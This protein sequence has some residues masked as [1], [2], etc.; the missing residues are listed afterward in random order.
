MQDPHEVEIGQSADCSRFR[1]AIEA[2]QSA[3]LEALIVAADASRP[4]AARGAL[5]ASPAGH[6][7][8]NAAFDLFECDDLYS[9]GCDVAHELGLCQER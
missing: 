2:K 9:L 1:R 8:V 3:R 4:A 7:L 6:A 5:F